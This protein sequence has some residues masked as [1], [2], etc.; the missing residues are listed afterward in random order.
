MGMVSF[1]RG[2]TLK[3][4]QVTAKQKYNFEMFKNKNIDRNR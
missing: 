4:S 2:I 1:S 3:S